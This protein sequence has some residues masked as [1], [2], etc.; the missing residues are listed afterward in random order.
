MNIINACRLI[1]E[2]LSGVGY[3]VHETG[4]INDYLALCNS[5]GKVTQLLDVKLKSGFR[6]YANMPDEVPFHT[7]HPSV[8]I[9][10][11]Y[12]LEQ[13]ETDGD[14]LLV[15]SRQIVSKLSEFSISVL[16]SL[17]LRMLHSEKPWPL[18]VQDPFQIYW[19]PLVVEEKYLQVDQQEKEAIRVFQ[20]ELQKVSDTENQY[21]VRLKP[22]ESLFINNH[23]LLHGRKSISQNS[24]RHLIRSYIL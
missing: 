17:Q 15:D 11:W 24:R 5:L 19:L 10:A 20:K 21:R 1:N 23:I 22:G 6:Q 12:C 4:S 13:D 16:K 8:P 7:D 14:N 18:L 3:Y 9:V 2:H